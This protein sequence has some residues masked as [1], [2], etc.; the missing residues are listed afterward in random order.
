MLL[1]LINFCE[2]YAQVTHKP[3]DLTKLLTENSFDI[4][5]AEDVTLSYKLS[6][7]RGEFG[8]AIK[9]LDQIYEHY[10]EVLNHEITR[11]L[12]VHEQALRDNYELRGQRP[13]H[14]LM[15]PL[16]LDG[17]DVTKLNAMK[18][19]DRIEEICTNENYHFLTLN[20]ARAARTVL[21][22]G[23]SREMRDLRDSSQIRRGLLT[24]TKIETPSSI[25]D[26]ALL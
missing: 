13:S 22:S 8:Q 18:M 14:T 23:M 25:K 3:I 11:E 6:Y 5:S 12:D 15:L 10:K 9:V 16:T 20:C 7:E 4:H 24:R 1:E 26:F 17:N 21:V 19:M 2:D